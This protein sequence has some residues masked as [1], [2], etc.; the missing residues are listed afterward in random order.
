MR[1]IIAIMAI[2]IL[3]AIA[4]WYGPWWSAALV[5]GISGL[6]SK[7]RTGKAFCGWLYGRRCYVDYLLCGKRHSQPPRIVEKMAQIFHLPSYL[8][9]ILVTFLLGG[10]TG[11]IPCWAGAQLRKIFRPRSFAPVS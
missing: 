4:E 6:L 7:L 2:I 5:A 1:P 3:A 8:F 11:G 10:L 9:Y